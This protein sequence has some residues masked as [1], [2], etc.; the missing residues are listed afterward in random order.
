MAQLSNVP[1]RIRLN[2]KVW[3]LRKIHSSPQGIS[4]SGTTGLI[5]RPGVARGK[6]LVADKPTAF[7]TRPTECGPL[8]KVDFEASG[9]WDI[10]A[11]DFGGIAD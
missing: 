4:I 5:M 6:L 3:F 10:V 11:K 1:A 7:V 9:N 8:Q 2:R